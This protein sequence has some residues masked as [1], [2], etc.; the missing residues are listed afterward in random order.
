MFPTQ[1]MVPRYKYKR[2]IT[3]PVHLPSTPADTTTTAQQIHAWNYSGCACSQHCYWYCIANTSVALLYLRIFPA[4]L[5][6]QQLLL[7][8][9][10]HGIIVAAHVPSTATGTATTPEQHMQQPLQNNTCSKIVA[11]ASKPKPA[12]KAK[13]KV[14][15]SAN[16][17]RWLAEMARAQC[18]GD[19]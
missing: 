3:V 16:R 9:Y 11:S 15:K 17:E 8:K 18:K 1:L 12:V 14:A 5:L 2:G 6:V 4:L 13:A 7:N 10:T 19:E